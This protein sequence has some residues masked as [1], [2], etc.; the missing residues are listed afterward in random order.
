MRPGD[1]PGQTRSGTIRGVTL[2]LRIALLLWIC[3][4]LLV[5][6]GPILGGHLVIG[7]ISLVGGIVLFVPWL[8]GVVVLVVL[9]SVTNS[10]RR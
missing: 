8:I 1:P 6:C 10:P 2:A 3:G 7:A 4:Y 9:I 5:S